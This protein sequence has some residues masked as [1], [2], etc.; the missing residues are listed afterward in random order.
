MT[1]ILMAT[2]VIFLG[3]ILSLNSQ[4]RPTGEHFFDKNNSNALRGFWCLIIV[5][6]HVPIAY[7]NRIQD[8]IGSFAYIGVTFFFMT[9]GYGL[10]LSVLKGNGLQSFWSRRLPKLLVP[11]LIVNIVGIVFALYEKNTINL[12][13]EFFRINDWVQWLLVCYCVF[14]IVHKFFMSRYTNALVCIAIIGFSI[15]IY[16]CVW[17]NVIKR[18]TWCPEIYGFVYGVILA[19]Y[20]NEIL[21]WM[22]S[23][24]I[25]KCIINC[26][27][28]GIF[29]FIYMKFKS[30]LFYGDYIL[31]IILGLVIIIFVLAI[32]CNIKIGN[33]VNTFLGNISYEI[34]LIHG[35]IFE[36]LIY[37][38]PKISSGLFIIVS[39]LLT[40]GI[41]AVIKSIS[42]ITVRNLFVEKH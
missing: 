25:K 33:R 41:S 27:I 6:V 32:N 37:I 17:K 26:L 10:K 16:I 23:Q 13:H 20:R 22:R 36:L 1:Y 30:V 12:W 2:L 28:V 7:S 14:W 21:K 18:T 24:W 29:G 42:N 5:L 34:Y 3:G 8:M 15:L 11:A 40:I 19:Q 9:S 35:C 4:Y 31:K 38:M 39:L